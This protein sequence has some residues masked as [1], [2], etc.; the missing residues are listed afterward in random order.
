MEYIVA[1]LII[2]VL[3]GLFIG[4]FIYVGHAEDGNPAPGGLKRD[5]RARP[6]VPPEESSEEASRDLVPK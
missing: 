1:Y 2:S 5:E 4:R 3:A 6:G